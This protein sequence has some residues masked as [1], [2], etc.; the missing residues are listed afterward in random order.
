MT[1]LAIVL[2]VSSALAYLVVGLYVAGLVHF[3]KIIVSTI[4]KLFFQ[5]NISEKDQ[6]ISSI[7]VLFIILSWPFVL[8]GMFLR[9][10]LIG[11]YALAHSSK[12]IKFSIS[13][14]STK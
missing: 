9:D 1:T 3:C 2:S 10:S 5:I 6:T 14:N 8:I 7:A 4:V 11:L 12:Q 13:T